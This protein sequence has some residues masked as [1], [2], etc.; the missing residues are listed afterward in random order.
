VP[1]RGPAAAAKLGAADKAFVVEHPTL[2]DFNPESHA[3]ALVEVVTKT[4]PSLVLVPNTSMG[5]DLAAALSARK[6]LPLVAY[7][8]GVAFEDG[9]IVATSQ[10]YAGKVFGRVGHRRSGGVVSVLA[11]S[12]PADAGR[13][14]Q[15]PP[16]ESVPPPASLGKLRLAFV[17]LV[18]PRAATSTSRSTSSWSRSAAAS[19]A[20]TSCR[21]SRSSRRRSAASCARRGPIVDNKWL[22]KTRQ[23]G[24]SGSKVKPK[25][26]LM[27]GISGAPEHIEGMKDAELIIAGQHRR[28]GAD[29]RA[30]ALRDDGGPVRPRAGADGK[31]AVRSPT[32]T[33]PIRTP[34]ARSS[35]TCP[36][37]RRSSST[38]SA[39]R[40]R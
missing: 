6:D 8:V 31:V 35:S 10:L 7:A 33:C 38:S 30:R 20:P 12:F 39:A 36:A 23:V 22:P 37:G 11:G 17:G 1:R 21:S 9:K 25:V 3:A 13:A 27:L 15:A 26:Y 29:L 16:V 19:G 2:S 5:M 24:K 32:V 28:A 40:R 18:E 34:P 14:D 4:S